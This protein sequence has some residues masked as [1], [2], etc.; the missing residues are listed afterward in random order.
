MGNHTRNQQESLIEALYDLAL[1]PNNFESFSLAWE[2]Y[3]LEHQL[4]EHDID[5][6]EN[7][8]RHFGRAFD[9]LEK[10]G[11]DQNTKNHN[12]QQFIE[13]RETPTIALELDGRIVALNQYATKLL[14]PQL[15]TQFAQ[16]LIHSKSSVSLNRGLDKISTDN[17]SLPIMVLLP[18]GQPML[19]VMQR[20]IDSDTIIVD[21]SG[22]EWSEHAQQ[23]LKGIYKLTQRECQIAA[24]LFHGKSLNQIAEEESRN[25]ETLRKHTKSLLKKTQTRSQPKL[26]RLL[27]SLNFAGE[28]Q[29][30]P[31]WH[32]T[33]TKN[34]RL[35]LVDGRKLAY[36]D[37]GQADK[38]VVAVLHGILHDPELPPTL[39]QAL[40]DADLRIVG[41]SRA[42]FGESSAA[43]DGGC[44]LKRAAA[45]LMRVL[46][47]LNIDSAILLGNMGGSIHAY[48]ASVL[49][50]QRVERV[51]NVA[52]MVPLSDETQIKAMPKGMRPV[53]YTAKYFPKL[54]PLFIRTAVA[55]INNGDIRNLFKTMY[56]D[57]PIDIA[58]IENDEIFRRL[59]RGFNFASFHG[60]AAYTSE[61]I[62]LVKNVTQYL[63]KITCR[64]D[65]IHGQHDGATPIAS[66]KDLSQQYDKFNIT[67]IEDA[68]KLL[69]YTSPCTVTDKVMQLIKP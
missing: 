52:G 18:N 63:D 49:Y 53:V 2:Q 14:K 24:S 30:P 12:V 38:P 40:L 51:I 3:L 55:M 66:V 7:L 29:S 45:D 69:M 22:A 5:V 56:R 36:Y 39:H 32:N 17:R 67:S 27:T 20:L 23:T 4:G 44:V 64:V 1:T 42:G 33:Q 41:I 10:I 26:M 43:T 58:A 34:H 65:L 15:E 37:T 8:A 11:R 13:A 57:S 25:I 62:D 48:A 59:E 31:K 60:H 28:N 19:M 68:G 21:I 46:D 16:E 54:L 50:P 35:K 6:S 47:E 61:T 9:I